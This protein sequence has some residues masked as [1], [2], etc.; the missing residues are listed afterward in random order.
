MW[1]THIV[2]RS[3][4]RT[5]Q[6]ISSA[7]VCV[8]PGLCRSAACMFPGRRPRFTG[9]T[10]EAAWG[11]RFRSCLNVRSRLAAVFILQLVVIVLLSE[12]WPTRPGVQGAA[13]RMRFAAGLS[14]RDTPMRRAPTPSHR[15][16]GPAA[17]APQQKLQLKVEVAH[18]RR[19]GS[20]VV[21]PTMGPSA[22]PTSKLQSD[23]GHYAGN[24]ELM[25]RAQQ[26]ACTIPPQA[27]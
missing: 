17:P 14:R 27:Q 16:I 25:P 19:S 21:L 12:C 5:G 9:G 3:E 7:D 15:A 11:R 26:T 8:W 20:I 23:G 10:P 1:R 6:E 4:A 24:I 2:I 22:S 18:G 13:R